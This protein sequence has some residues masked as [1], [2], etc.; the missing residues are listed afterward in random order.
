MSCK[1]EAKSSVIQKNDTASSIQ[2]TTQ[3]SLKQ[4]PTQPE[5]F[6]FVTDL[7]DSKGY[8]DA[9]KYS[10]EEIEGTYKLW[11]QMGGVSLITPSVFKLNDLEEIRRDKDLILAKLDKDF[12]ENKKTIENLKVVNVPY[13]QNIKELHYKSLL[14]QYEYEKIH[15]ASYPDPSVLLHNKFTGKCTN[16]AKAVNSNDENL[17]AE[18][19]KLREEMSKRNGSPERII[20]EF[21]NRLNSSNWKDYAMIDLL[22]FGWG[23]CANEYIERSLHDEKMYNEFNA[24]FIKI[25]SE[26]DE[27]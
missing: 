24:L 22:T 5:V 21:E 4:K 13:W 10:R 2:K 20:T 17:I 1:K 25:D 16:F 15:I 7:C 19:R 26:C 23:N 14:Q 11:F 12:A 9:E 18:W 6:A 27:P 8:F 3:D